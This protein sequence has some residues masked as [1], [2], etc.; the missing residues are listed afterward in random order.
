MSDYY[1]NNKNNSSSSE[2]TITLKEQKDEKKYYISS[3]KKV[4]QFT[5]IDF[6][7]FTSRVLTSFF[8][9]CILEF[10]NNMQEINLN[11]MHID[12]YINDLLKQINELKNMNQ[13]KD[14]KIRNLKLRKFLQ[15]WRDQQKKL[16]EKT[17]DSASIIQLA[18]K[19]Y[20]ARKERDRL[21]RIKNLLYKLTLHKDD[22]I[23]NKLYI[24]L[25]KWVAIAKN[26][27]FNEN[28]SKIQ[29]YWK[30]FQ[31][32]LKNDK[33]KLLDIKFGARHSI[34]KLISEKNRKIFTKFN[35]DLKQKRLDTLKNCFDKIKK[36]GNDNVLKQLIKIPDAFKKRILKKYLFTL[37]DK[38][39]KLAKK[40]GADTI[41][42]NWRIY[43][44]KKKVFL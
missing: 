16:G 3:N 26:M 27:T 28:A 23:N 35:D 7:I 9:N 12:D 11:I 24:T 41:I 6:K 20:M 15:R 2:S 33:E 30:K 31:N 29:K 8:I 25:R 38:T 32:K 22:I 42:K 39:D 14:N 34:D 44:N 1:R 4:Y 40:R 13:D 36:R 17:N 21:M 5:K 37:R 18:F 43:I 19:G 10:L